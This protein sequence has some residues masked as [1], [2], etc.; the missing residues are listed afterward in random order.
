MHADTSTP[1]AL[2]CNSSAT[3]ALR[4]RA[5]PA[6]AP[7]CSVR[8]DEE[9]RGQPGLRATRLLLWLLYMG[10]DGSSAPAWAGRQ[11]APTY[12]PR[13]SARGRDPTR[14][15][16]PPGGMKNLETAGSAGL[17]AG[18]QLDQRWLV[19]SSI[20]WPSPFGTSVSSWPVGYAPARHGAFAT[21]LDARRW[22]VSVSGNLLGCDGAWF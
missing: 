6:A 19:G 20:S 15:I 12:T 13:P 7:H 1:P 18:A 14:Q 11:S 22:C 3:G 21:G 9:G 8:R 17:L 5:I 10:G 4:L 16:T 2:C